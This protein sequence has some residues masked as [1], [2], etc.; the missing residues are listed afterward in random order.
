MKPLSGFINEV[1]GRRRKLCLVLWGA[2]HLALTKRHKEEI[3]RTNDANV[4]ISKKD[5]EI[6][7]LN[8]K[9]SDQ[10]AR[11]KILEAQ[12]EE[13]V[14]RDRTKSSIPELD[15][16][17]DLLKRNQLLETFEKLAATT[18]VSK[19]W[20]EKVQ[21]NIVVKLIS[22]GLMERRTEQNGSGYLELTPL[23]KKVQQFIL[24]S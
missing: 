1:S 6:G 21:D 7:A 10:N 16:A 3:Q 4:T 18:T 20:I 23:G 5:Q 12:V 22:Q 2:L 15:K 13:F 11:T 19:L 8:S 24:S 17:I 9:L 14:L